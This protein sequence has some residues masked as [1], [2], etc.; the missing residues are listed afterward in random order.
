MTRAVGNGGEPDVPALRDRLVS[1]KQ[2]Q[3]VTKE[4][5]MPQAV[6]VV[7]SAS[8]LIQSS[9]QNLGLASSQE[10]P[11]VARSP[12]SDDSVFTG[13]AWGCSRSSPAS[14]CSRLWCHPRTR[15]SFRSPDPT[16]NA[17]EWALRRADDKLKE[18]EAQPPEIAVAAYKAVNSPAGAAAREALAK[19]ARSRRDLRSPSPC[20]RQ[21]S[22]W[23][24][25]Q[26]RPPRRPLRSARRRSRQVRR[27]GWVPSS[28][29]GTTIGTPSRPP[30]PPYR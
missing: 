17:V 25:L 18:I 9:R 5:E 22:C 2:L 1:L 19:R 29:A 15:A 8:Y 13:A 7:H 14:A 16:G 4:V 23:A 12:S 28:A 26:R 27:G 3:A 30:R 6:P 20:R 10:T 24:T 21:E 11:V